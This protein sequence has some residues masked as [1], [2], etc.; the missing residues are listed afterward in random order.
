[1][2]EIPALD[3]AKMYVEV[4]AVGEDWADK[5]AAY[6]ALDDVSKSVLADITGSYMDGKISKAQAEMYALSSKGY[7]E[8]LASV[9]IARQAW[10]RAQVRYDSI[11]MLSEL[12]RTQEST[13]RAEMR[14]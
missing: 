10:L 5:K 14:L 3:P 1:M 13:R 4:M 2:S 6:E 8:H 9:A 7:R 12:R 11:K